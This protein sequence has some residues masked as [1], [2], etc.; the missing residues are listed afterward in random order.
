MQIITKN[1]KKWLLF[2]CFFSI[3]ALAIEADLSFEAGYV[4]GT[5]MSSEDVNDSHTFARWGDPKILNAYYFY[6]SNNRASFGLTHRFEGTKHLYLEIGITTGYTKNEVPN[7]IW[8]SDDI[9]FIAAPV[10]DLPITKHWNFKGII[11]GDSIN[12]GVS[13]AF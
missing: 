7:N 13:Y 11:L 1:L 9:M 10:L 12:G 2:G 5:H 3:Q 4:Y 6:N 8:F